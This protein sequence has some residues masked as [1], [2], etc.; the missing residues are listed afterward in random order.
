VVDFGTLNTNPYSNRMPLF[1]LLLLSFFTSASQSAPS[2][3]AQTAP[4][5]LPEKILNIRDIAGQTQEDIATILGHQSQLDAETAARAGCP[6]C[7]K[8]SYQDG[9]VR[10][11]YIND[12]ADWLTITPR[13][14]VPAEHTP[15]L[16]GLPAATP[17]YTDNK[18]L[19]WNRYEGIRKISAYRKA[20]G[21]IDYIYMKVT[22]P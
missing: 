12:M 9:L 8:Y 21:T 14:A 3:N 4:D 17:D 2:S 1:C 10:I 7:Q 16:L 5:S 19:R 20:D 6:T 18:V 11:V 13:T 22:T 15:T